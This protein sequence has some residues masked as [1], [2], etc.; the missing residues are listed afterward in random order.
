MPEGVARQRWRWAIAAS[1]LVGRARRRVLRLAEEMVGFLG[2][3]E[4]EEVELVVDG[5]AG[6]GSPVGRSIGFV[7]AVDVGSDI[8][9]VVVVGKEAQLGWLVW[10]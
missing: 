3:E 9:V 4:E 2:A 8:L 7:S 10:W 5:A 1:D 6:M